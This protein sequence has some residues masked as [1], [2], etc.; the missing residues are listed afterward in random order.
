VAGDPSKSSAEG[1][2]G[3]PSGSGGASAGGV[4]GGSAGGAGCDVSAWSG[5]YGVIV[6]NPQ[7]ECAQSGGGYLARSLDHGVNSG[8]GAC[9][10]SNLASSDDG[11]RLS[12]EMECGDGVSL[13]LRWTV[14][15][16]ALDPAGARLLSHLTLTVGYQDGGAPCTGEW[17]E[18]LTRT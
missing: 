17:D 3:T 12:Y 7:G 2:G 16:S 8:A 1:S 11:C 10:V 18:L 14:E 5:T 4:A 9:V 13:A 15:T 6:E